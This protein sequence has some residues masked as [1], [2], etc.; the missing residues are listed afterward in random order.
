MNLQPN[1]HRSTLICAIAGPTASGKSR[2]AMSVAETLQCPII[3]VD[4]MQ[5]YRGLDIG[6]AKPT[7]EDQQKVIHYGLDLVNPVERFSSDRYT[8][9]VEPVL[10]EA[11]KNQSHV[12]LCGGTGFYFR[13]LLE[14]FVETP[15]PDLE[16]RENLYERLDEKGREALYKDLME[17]DPHTAGSIHRNDTKRVIRAL[18][19][20]YQTG[21]SLTTLKQNQPKKEWLQH[22]CFIGLQ[23]Q[24][25]LLRKRI[26]ERTY[27][28][29]ENGLIDET[30]QMLNDGCKPNDTAMQ[31]LGYKECADYINQ[32][33]SIEEAITATVHHTAQ[34]AKRQRTWFRHQFPVQ[35]LKCMENSSEKELQEQCLQIW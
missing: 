7:V 19:I 20:Y 29:Y 10:K 1:L 27:W 26:K 16:L 18:E 32:Q 12:I 9:L 2:L 13:A 30:Q 21:E 35:W 3:C 24:P 31:A 6:T 4:S 8:K 25:E 34:Y 5:V 23:W 14:G 17:I 33:C 28:M 22:T 11:K 15:D